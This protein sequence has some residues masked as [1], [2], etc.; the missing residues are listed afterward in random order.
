MWTAQQAV[1]E[2]RQMTER[3]ECS[4]AADMAYLLRVRR[5][6][7]DLSPADQFELQQMY[8]SVVKLQGAK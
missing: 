5:I 3:R 6:L 1:S 2:L 4:H 7:E 8:K